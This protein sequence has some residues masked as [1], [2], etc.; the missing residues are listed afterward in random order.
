MDHIH[1]RSHW[2]RPATLR[3]LSGLK[4]PICWSCKLSC[5]FSN[6]ESRQRRNAQPGSDVWKLRIIRQLQ[7][8]LWTVSHILISAV[9]WR[10]HWRSVVSSQSERTCLPITW[11][12]C[13][14][15]DDK[16]GSGEFSKLYLLGRLPMA[17]D[18]FNPR[19]RVFV[20]LLLLSDAT[21]TGD[22]A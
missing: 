3:L 2:H 18:L 16:I 11:N 15:V 20:F 22:K 8:W 19:A 6:Y 14:R 17:I 12:R 1:L 4:Q 13:N 5:R 7:R 21:N 9:H 10:I